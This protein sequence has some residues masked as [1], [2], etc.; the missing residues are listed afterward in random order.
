MKEEKNFKIENKL[1]YI[2]GG[3]KN[4]EDNIIKEKDFSYKNKKKSFL[5]E[6]ENIKPL[7]IF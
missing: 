3:Y 6:E 7:K 4:N 1:R 5:N 2:N